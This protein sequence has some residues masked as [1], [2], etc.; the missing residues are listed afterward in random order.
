MKYFFVLF[1]CF[2]YSQFTIKGKL[3]GYDNKTIS[4]RVS[5]G[6]QDILYEK[7]ETD[8]NGNFIFKVKEKYIGKLYLYYNSGLDFI[9]FFSDN[10][11]IELTSNYE[12]GK[13]LNTNFLTSEVNQ[14]NKDYEEYKVLNDSVLPKLSYLENFY[15]NRNSNLSLFLIEEILSVKKLNQP[16]IYL[17]PVLKYYYTTD[18]Q[19]I[20]NVPNENQEEINKYLNKLR[21]LF[22]NSDGNLETSGLMYSLLLNYMTYSSYGSKEKTELNHKLKTSLNLLLDEVN[23][24]T[25][26]GQLVQLGIINMLNSYGMTSLSDEFYSQASSMKCD[27]IPNL[28]KKM[29][30]IENLKVGKVFPDTKFTPK[31][32]F[33][34]TEKSL[35]SLKSKYKVVVFWVSYC[36]HCKQELNY[37]KGIYTQIKQKK[38]EI[39]GLS[40]DG[41]ENE[42]RRIANDLPW[43]SDCEMNSR[44]SSYYEKYNITATPT[45][46]ILDS[47]NKIIAVNPKASTILNYLN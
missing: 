46:Y 10:T 43:I 35:Y 19:F 15:S 23:R 20:K 9:E 47:Q 3:N 21:N 37:L 39:I 18:E 5:S 28:K 27:I 31:Y 41:N 26:R 7:V 17:F 42:F 25:T 32:L 12:S 45:V 11:S 22:K 1:F 13:L 33:N 2:S 34:S 24:E 16:N 40:V 29:T 6:T 44:D 14:I 30:A 36:S 38:G 4:L 8:I